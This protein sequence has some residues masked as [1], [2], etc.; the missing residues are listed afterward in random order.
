M[1]SLFNHHELELFSQLVWQLGSGQG[2]HALRQQT[3]ETVCALLRADFAASCIWSPVSNTSS[4]GVSWN[5]DESAMREHAS[6]WQYIDPITPLLRAKQRATLVDEVMGPRELK[7]SAFYNEFL[8]P[9]GMHHGVNVYFVRDG[10][11]VGDLRIWRAKGAPAFGQREIQLL[12]L[13]EPWFVK[14]LP[15]RDKTPRLTPREQEVASLVCKGLSD[16]EVA[17]LLNI[18]FTTVRTH[19]NQALKKLD[20]ANRTELASRF[21]H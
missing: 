7:K 9:C 6:T 5:I 13:L 8:K 20:C 10:E 3:L 1:E 12:H 14:A 18:G 16:K 17:R 19:L 4:H 2:S 21:K 11:D 15:A